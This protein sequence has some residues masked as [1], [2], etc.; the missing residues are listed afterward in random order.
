MFGDDL[1]AAVHTLDHR[2]DLRTVD[3]DQVALAAHLVDQIFAGDRSGLGV[4]GFDGGIGTLGLGIDGDHNDAGRLGAADRRGD[5]IGI[6]GIEKDKVDAGG[7]EIVDLV[8]LLAQIVVEADGG[9]LY[10]RV[11]LLCLELG[12][13]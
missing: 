10:V 8:I 12:T 9:D 4:V 13:F 1:L 11:G 3:D 7:D 5:G 6:A 2:G